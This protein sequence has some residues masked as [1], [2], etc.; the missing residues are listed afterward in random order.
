[1]VAYTL[2]LF[3]LLLGLHIGHAKLMRRINRIKLKKTWNWNRNLKKNKRLG[4]E[5]QFDE[6]FAGS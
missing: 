6:L 4:F 5:D 3:F 2:I 1:M